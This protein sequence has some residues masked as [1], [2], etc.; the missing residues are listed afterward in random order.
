MQV[1]SIDVRSKL[2]E[3]YSLDTD[4]SNELPYCKIL[5]RLLPNEIR[6][7][8]WRPVP[9]DFSARFDCVQRTYKYYF[10]K[11]NL[12]LDVSWY[13]CSLPVCFMMQQ[14]YIFYQNFSVPFT[15]R[16]TRINFLTFIL[17]F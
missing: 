17:H 15:M 8:A 3:N 10:P 2:Q 6:A 16:N 1:I 12:N 7:V 11:G 13:L 9:V 14:D 4:T 5:N